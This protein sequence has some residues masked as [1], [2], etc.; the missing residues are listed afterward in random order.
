MVTW[1]VRRLSLDLVQQTLSELTAVAP[2]DAVFF[3]EIAFPGQAQWV[4]DAH[5]NGIAGGYMLFPSSQAPCGTATV[6]HSRW[7]GRVHQYHSAERAVA[8]QLHG[9]KDTIN[10]LNVHLPD[11]RQEGMK[12]V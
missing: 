9:Q 2:W 5:T 4:L 1:N 11:Y 6:I 10:L 7:R 8:L 12:G 3:Q